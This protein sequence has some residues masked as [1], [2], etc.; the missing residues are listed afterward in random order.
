M[1]S[2]QQKEKPDNPYT[3]LDQIVDLLVKKERDNDLFAVGTG[4]GA[5][6]EEIYLVTVS[7]DTY[8]VLTVDTA[9]AKIV[10]LVESLTDIIRSNQ[11]FLE[12]FTDPH[13]L[14]DRYR[15]S[16]FGPDPCDKN[17]DYI[18]GV[19]LSHGRIRYS[20][21]DLSKEVQP[22]ENVHFETYEEA[23]E[24]LRG[25]RKEATPPCGTQCHRSQCELESPVTLHSALEDA[26]FDYLNNGVN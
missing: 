12:C 22:A 3:R 5:S 18:T 23:V 16:I 25:S 13:A 4:G 10:K 26:M 1:A 14:V 15:L 21:L 2:C 19:S 7:F 24:I 20:R 17:Q 6:E 11:A 9:R 8:D